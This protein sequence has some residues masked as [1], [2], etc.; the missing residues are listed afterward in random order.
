MNDRMPH[1][2]TTKTNTLY[3]HTHTTHT[4]PSHFCKEKTQRKVCVDEWISRQA[5]RLTGTIPSIKEMQR[6]MARKKKERNKK[7]KCSSFLAP[8][9]GHIP[10]IQFR[11]DL[12]K[13]N[14]A[15]EMIA[16]PPIPSHPIP[17]IPPIHTVH[18]VRIN[19][20]LVERVCKS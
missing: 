12:V 20:P 4:H 13:F 6:W 8:L 19:V 18:A 17:P 7:Q 14:F 1:G 15:C 2:Q 3:T 10:N 11:R 5:D 16:I 9:S